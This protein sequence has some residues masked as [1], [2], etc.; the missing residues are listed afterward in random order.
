MIVRDTSNEIS[1][2]FISCFALPD[3]AD[4]RVRHPVKRVCLHHH[5]NQNTTEKG[6]HSWNEFSGAKRLREP[7]VG[8]VDV[9][10][11]HLRIPPYE[12]SRDV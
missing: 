4:E 7:I 3:I 6:A 2:E 1:P 8:A 12:Q 5:R 10:I 11:V 9:L